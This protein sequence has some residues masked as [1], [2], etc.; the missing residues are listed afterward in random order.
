MELHSALASADSLADFALLLRGETPILPLLCLRPVAWVSDH[1]Q[2]GACV[3]A[4]EPVNATEPTT[5]TAT[6]P[7]TETTTETATEPTTETTTETATE[8]TTTGTSI[9]SVEGSVLTHCP[10][11][12]ESLVEQLAAA[13]LPSYPDHT[14]KLLFRSAEQ[15]TLTQLLDAARGQMNT[16]LIVV[17]ADGDVLGSFQEEPW[18][19]AASFYG[20]GKSRVF[21]VGEEGEIEWFE[22]SKVNSFFQLSTETQLIVGGGNRHAIFLDA[23]LKH[24]ASGECLTFRSPPLVES[25]EF[26]CEVVEL[27]CSS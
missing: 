18:R 4:T 27:W 16:L 19:Y 12:P 9:E 22:W 10:H 6:E 23:M 15:A 11:V 8:T 25:S 7:T 20:T 21:R 3:R 1:C 26:E 2:P 17:T 5:E 14:P 13:L 24:G